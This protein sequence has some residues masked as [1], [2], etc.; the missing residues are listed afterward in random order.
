M[1]GP[2]IILKAFEWLGIVILAALAILLVRA[3]FRPW[4]EGREG[5]RPYDRAH[6]SPAEPYPSP[7]HGDGP[8]GHADE[9][10]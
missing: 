4:K 10:G 6:G 7:R 9:G 3:L 8:R 5:N 1:S 2:D